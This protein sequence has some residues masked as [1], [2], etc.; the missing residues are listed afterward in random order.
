MMGDN[1][2]QTIHTIEIY[3]KVISEII[4]D[5]KGRV[6]DSPGDNILAEF[7][8]AVDVVEASIQIQNQLALRNAELSKNRK[9]EFRIGINLGDVILKGD[10]VYGDA[11][12][13]A[14]RIE[15]LADPGG[16]CISNSLYSQVKNKLNLGYEYIGGHKVKNISEPVEVYRILTDKNYQSKDNIIEFDVPSAPSIAILPF[17]N[18]SEDQ[19]QEFI[20]N[21]IAEEIITALSKVPKIFVISRN[22]SF[23]FKN[24]SKK[25]QE[26]GRE[27]GVQYIVEGSIRKSGNILRITAQLVDASSGHQLWANRYDRELKDLFSLQDEI[28]FKIL[29]ALQVKLTDGEQATFWSKRTNNL[30]AFLKYLQARYQVWGITKEGHFKAKQLAYEAID[31]DEKYVDPYILIAWVNMFEARLG[32]SDSREESFKNAVLMVHKAER[33]E[34]NH[35]EVHILLGLIHLYHREHREAVD[36]SQRA[37]ALGPNNADVHAVMSTILRSNG[38]FEEATAMIRKAIRLQPYHPAWFLGE[39]SMCLYYLNRN[40]EA[41]AAAHRFK[42]ISIDRGETELVYWHYT[43]LAMNYIRLN[44][45]KDAQ[46]ASKKAL[47]EFPGYSLEWDRRY[48][49]YKSKAHLER[50]HSDLLKAGIR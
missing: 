42:D 26:I 23:I 4:I 22:S 30:D 46:E 11:V 39:L 40:N 19:D 16:V 33:L 31:T 12:N 24:K 9:M 3:R 49:L 34:D 14:A 21:G 5:Y 28:A 7:D 2:L 6:V 25:A 35:P 45:V 15:S 48:S 20:S 43:M 41:L 50:Q 37:I 18:L 8:S 17:N 36:R 10:R 38:R 44:R 47:E 27:L 13:V 29:T 32:W 1:E